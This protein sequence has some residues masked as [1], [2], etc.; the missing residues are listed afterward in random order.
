MKTEEIQEA[1][2]QFKVFEV[3]RYAKQHLRKYDFATVLGHARTCNWLLG[4]KDN[5]S[6]GAVITVG[7]SE[8]DTR[9]V[10]NNSGSVRW[11]R[12]DKLHRDSGLPASYGKHYTQYFENGV[13]KLCLDEKGMIRFD[14]ST[15]F[16]SNGLPVEKKAF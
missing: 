8:S 3:L 10:I 16:E 11:Y 2:H 14:G 9:V 12:G 13:E 5:S 7:G 1:G 4:D 15:H 6:V